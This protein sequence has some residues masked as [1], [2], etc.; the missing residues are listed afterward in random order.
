MTEKGKRNLK[1][2][3]RNIIRVLVLIISL[4]VL[5]IGVL[6]YFLK[7]QVE[8]VMRVHSEDQEYTLILQEIGEAEG[9]FG[10]S[11][12]RL[13]LMKEDKVIKQYDFTYAGYFGEDGCFCHVTWNEESVEIRFTER[14][15]VIVTIYYDGSEPI[16]NEED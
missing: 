4:V 6:Y 1:L 7:W 16:L 14:G 12:G 2:I 8:E 3:K 15:R 10:P 9:L 11:D 13:I 5:T